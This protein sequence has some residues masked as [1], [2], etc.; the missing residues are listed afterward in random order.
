MSSG[1]SLGGGRSKS[2]SSS[3]SASYGY[4]GSESQDASVSSQ[5]AQNSGASQST[6]AQSVAFADYLNGL[7]GGATKAASGAAM[8]ADDLTATSKMLFTG[9]QDFLSSIGG[10]A[11]TNYMQDRLNGSDDIL[12]EQ[13][14]ALSADTSKFFNEQLNPAITA[15]AVTGGQLGGGR[16]GV[17]QA[18]AV[19]ATLEN[20]TKGVTALRTAD[21]AQKDQI[22]AQ[23]AVNSLVGASTGL[24]AL[25]ML[26]DLQERGNNAELGVYSA[27]ASILGGPTV[28]SQSQSTSN[29]QGTS[30]AQSVAQAFS[31]SFGEQTSEAS[32]RGK[33]SAWNFDSS[34][35]Y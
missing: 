9:G 20:Y 29:T 19:D 1:F 24:G 15:S 4:S 32:S 34:A 35:S 2:N 26:L 31:R 28:L 3:E 5:F 14:S 7:Y 17:A 21:R 6:T 22:A 27:L 8:N 16:Q 12:N 33:S 10:D 30:T 23:V 25:P 11:G 13:I 18:R